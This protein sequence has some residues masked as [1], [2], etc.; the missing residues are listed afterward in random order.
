MGVRELWEGRWGADV[1]VF[2]LN[3]CVASNE[4]LPFRL[5]GSHIDRVVS[6]LVFGGRSSVPLRRNVGRGVEM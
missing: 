2:I 6:L 1:L 5:S 4:G 3:G